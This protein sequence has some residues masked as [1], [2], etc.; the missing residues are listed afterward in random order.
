[1]PVPVGYKAHP[2]RSHIPH[3][4]S[5]RGMEYV[6]T[7]LY[8][9]RLGEVHVVDSVHKVL[10]SDALTPEETAVQ[11]LDGV[12]ASLDT[13][14]FDVD[15]SVSRSGSNA[16]VHYLPVAAVAL[17]F[18]ILFEL[19]VPTRFLSARGYSQSEFFA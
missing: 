9:G 17:F 13:V 19:S 4:S 2:W 7:Y 14:K 15:L 5:R 12:L 18:D 6:A 10:C 3:I 8:V 1:M 16:D 11:A